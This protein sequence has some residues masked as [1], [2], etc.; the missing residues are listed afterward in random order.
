[1]TFFLDDPI[2]SNIPQK[3]SLL[4]LV[5]YYG[6]LVPLLTTMAKLCCR[7]LGQSGNWNLSAVCQESYQEIEAS[8][9]CL[10]MLVHCDPMRPCSQ[11]VMVPPTALVQSYP[12]SAEMSKEHQFHMALER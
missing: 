4:V 7:L 12:M 11:P 9:C 1:M 8:F 2:P 5:K 10:S 3:R 6:K